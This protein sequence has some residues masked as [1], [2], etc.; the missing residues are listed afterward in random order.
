MSSWVVVAIPA[1]NDYVWRVSSEKIPH[2]TMLFLG[3]QEMGPKAARITSFVEHVATTLKRFGLEVDRRGKLGDDDADVLFFMQDKQI[4]ELEDVRSALLK[5]KEIAEAYNSV[6]QY[7]QWTPHLTLGYPAT[8]AKDDKRDFP[9]I[10]WVRFDRLA[11]W[12]GDY[13][14]PEFVLKDIREDELSMAEQDRVDEFLAHHGVKGMK[15]GVRRSQ[16]ELDRLA[17]RRESKKARLDRVASGKA[18]AKD[19]VRTAAEL[20]GVRIA[21]GGGLSGAAAKKASS[22]RMKDAKK[23]AK[24]EAVKKVLEKS[25]GD[26]VPSSSS[27]KQNQPSRPPMKVSSRDL[28]VTKR[29][30]NDY[31]NLSDHD[32][33]YKYATSK[34]RYAKAV[35]KHGD[36]YRAAKNTRT[37]RW[38]EKQ[39]KKISARIDK[40]YE[41]KRARSAKRQA[42]KDIRRSY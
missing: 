7:P 2:M 11:V 10:N 14:G 34:N 12:Y 32:F 36:P 23:E 42:I 40:K 17:G 38:A 35:A 25:A 33:F 13:E 22:M 4:A 19:K 18:S 20:G 1:E 27:L 3:E 9:G 28:A 39:N 15:W 5:N 41:K 26:R 31:N 37:G 29:A 8:P 6:E 30:K 21:L 24:K 16:V